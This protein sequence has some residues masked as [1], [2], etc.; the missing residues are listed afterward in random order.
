VTSAKLRGPVA[1]DAFPLLAGFDTITYSSRAHIS[2]GVRER[3]YAPAYVHASQPQ[4]LA[5]VGPVGEVVDGDSRGIHVI[6]PCA[7]VL[8]ATIS[9]IVGILRLSHT[10]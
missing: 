9:I 4:Q 2:Q 6:H 7:M 10:S 8:L 3:P 1:T 5:H